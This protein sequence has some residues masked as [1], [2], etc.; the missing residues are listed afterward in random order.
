MGAIAETMELAGK[1]ATFKGGLLDSCAEVV[2]SDGARQL[3]RERRDLISSK[4][5]RWS[6][7][8]NSGKGPDSWQ[9]DAVNL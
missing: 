5:K 3:A 8:A 9:G 1:M 6:P 4:S 2:R 7:T